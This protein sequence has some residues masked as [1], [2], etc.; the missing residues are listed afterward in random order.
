MDEVYEW[1]IY[2]NREMARMCTVPGMWGR[3]INIRFVKH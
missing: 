3:T 1:I 2:D